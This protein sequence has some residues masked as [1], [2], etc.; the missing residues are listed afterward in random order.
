M[1]T[2]RT[3]PAFVTLYEPAGSLAAALIG[4]PRTAVLL[5]LTETADGTPYY[6]PAMRGTLKE[7]ADVVAQLTTYEQLDAGPALEPIPLDDDDDAADAYVDD[8]PVSPA[9]AVATDVTA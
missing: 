2:D 1:T 8:P 5:R 9:V 7:V 3:A 4:A 6:Q